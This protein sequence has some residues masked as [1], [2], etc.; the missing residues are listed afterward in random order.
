MNI[1]FFFSTRILNNN[2]I[3][4]LHQHF[5][6]LEWESER[7]WFK[8][9]WKELVSN[10]VKCWW[11]ITWSSSKNVFNYI[12]HIC[13]VKIKK[14]QHLVR[15][16]SVFN[17]W[18]EIILRWLNLVEICTNS[19]LCISSTLLPIVDSIDFILF[20]KLSQADNEIKDFWHELNCTHFEWTCI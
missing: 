11:A 17:V 3:K 19:T 2:L 13:L 4:S 16:Y 7:V 10:S 18:A 12:G 20:G 6:G 8:S 1:C 15:N 14:N 5:V 9:A